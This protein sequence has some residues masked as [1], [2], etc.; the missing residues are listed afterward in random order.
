MIKTSRCFKGQIWVETVIYT[1]IALVLIGAVLVVI[2]PKI[3]ALQDRTMIENSIGIM[4][5]INSKVLEVVQGGPGNIRELQIQLRSGNIIVDGKE[6]TIIFQMT[7]SDV[8]S[9]PGEDV[10]YG[11]IIIR[12]EGETRENTVT[13]KLNYSESYNIKLKT[14]ENLNASDI[15]KDFQKAGTPYTFVISNN[16]KDIQ[17]KPVIN[18]EVK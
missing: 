18:I 4:N 6:D 8:F 15:M 5:Q 10:N 1:L 17:G 2:K 14:P 3:E 12:T 7:S 13:L 16:G 9:Q 11:P